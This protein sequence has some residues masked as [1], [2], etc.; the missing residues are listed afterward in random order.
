MPAFWSVS[1]VR[2]LCGERAGHQQVLPSREADAGMSPLTH[3]PTRV[4]V[5]AWRPP[6]QPGAAGHC[7]TPA[8]SAT[9]KVVE[10][11]GLRE[12]NGHPWTFPEIRATISVSSPQCW[13]GRILGSSWTPVPTAAPCAPVLQ[14]RRRHGGD[15]SP[16]GPG[17]SSGHSAGMC[18]SV[19]ERQAHVRASEWAVC[20]TC[21][22][23][24]TCTHPHAC[25]A[26]HAH[27]HPREWGALGGLQGRG[28]LPG[29]HLLPAL[30]ARL[31]QGF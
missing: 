29:L 8:G 30:D 9:E 4:P 18:A 16:R 25:T 17:H 10:G 7:G 21:A 24:D 15:S 20:L 11:S 6:H 28:H 23:T 19:P 1:G 27:V 14:P 22:H 2:S 12:P 3:R 5:L 31:W 13:V 26:T